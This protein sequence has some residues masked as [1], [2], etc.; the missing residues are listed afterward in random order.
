MKIF[1]YRYHCLYSMLMDGAYTKD[2]DEDE[3]DE[4]EED[5]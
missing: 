4:E 3:D 2:P 5:D 1:N